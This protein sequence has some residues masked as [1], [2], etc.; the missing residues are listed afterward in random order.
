MKR[1]IVSIILVI[2]LAANSV[3]AIENTEDPLLMDEITV[4]SNQKGNLFGLKAKNNDEIIVNA[5]YKKLIRLG[6]SSWIIN[7]KNKYGLMDCSGKILVEPKFRHVDRMLGKYVKLGNENDYGVFNEKGENIIPN[8]YMSIDMLFG[9]M[10]LV[11]KDYKYGVA[12][13]NGKL[14]L[15]TIFDDI[16]MPKPNI[17]RIQYNGQWYEI[18]QIAGGEIELPEDVKNIK[19][20]SNF[21]VTEF[22]KSPI[23]ASGY[24]AVTFTDYFLKLFSSISPSHEET[25]DE[26]MLSQG[27]DTVNIFIKCTWLPKYPFTF[28]KK[29]YHNV[30]T[31]NNGPLSNV[32]SDLKKKLDWL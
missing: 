27:A 3:L 15:N 23:T 32:K 12:N 8:E 20:N 16:Y 13:K 9:E 22:V 30:R 18:E 24:S 19:E 28:A 14:I 21:K 11:K 5:Q 1:R 4:F 26:L 10:F 31:P 6:N 25:I 17:M 29:Y 7:Q 2:L